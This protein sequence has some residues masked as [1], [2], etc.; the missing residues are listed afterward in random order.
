MHPDV[1]V[2][3]HWAR[4]ATVPGWDYPIDHLPGGVTGLQARHRDVRQIQ[5]EALVGQ[6][7]VVEGRHGRRGRKR[8]AVL[9]IRNLAAMVASRATAPFGIGGARAGIDNLKRDGRRVA[10]LSQ[11]VVGAV[12]LGTHELKTLAATQVVVVVARQTGPELRVVTAVG[13]GKVSTQCDVVRVTAEIRVRCAEA[14]A[15][16]GK[17]A[18][19]TVVC[20]AQTIQAEV[21]GPIGGQTEMGGTRIVPGLVVADTMDLRPLARGARLAADYRAL[22]GTRPSAR[23]TVLGFIVV[24]AVLGAAHTVGHRPGTAGGCTSV[25]AWSRTAQS[26]VL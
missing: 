4:H 26:G 8:T 20:R 3:L 12:I 25:R 6:R 17:L 24:A 1:D 21:A 11:L 18:G 2:A 15:F 9:E 19:G 5:M 22:S 10:G 14:S 16:V 23:R 7:V 13:G